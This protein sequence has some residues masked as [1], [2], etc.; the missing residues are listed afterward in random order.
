MEIDREEDQ[1]TEQEQRLW[2]RR[3]DLKKHSRRV[4]VDGVRH[5]N[6]TRTGQK[7]FWNEM[8]Y[9]QENKDEELSYYQRLSKYYGRGRRGSTAVSGKQQAVYFAVPPTFS[10]FSTRDF[11]RMRHSLVD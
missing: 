11:L 4:G 2:R 9:T 3:M 5:D 8:N 10:L 7:D 1:A 6:M